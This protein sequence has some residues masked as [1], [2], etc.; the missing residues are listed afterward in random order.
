[1]VYDSDIREQD[2]T[3][4]DTATQ[5]SDIGGSTP[6]DFQVPGNCK[7]ITKISIGTAVDWTADTLLGFGSAVHLK[8]AGLGTAGNFA[9]PGPC[10][11]TG[12]AA[13]TSSGLNISPAQEYHTNIPVVAGGNIQAD[14]YMFGEDVGSVRVACELEYD[15]IPGRIVDMDY[16]ESD[17]TAANTE[18]QLTV[19][20]GATVND[21]KTSGRPIVEVHLN[22]GLKPVAGPLGSVVAYQL[23][24]AALVHAGNYMYVGHGYTVQDDPTISGAT[25]IQ[26][27]VRK[28]VSSIPLKGGNLLNCYAQML[29]DDVGT[30]FAV[31]GLGFG[32]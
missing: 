6:G 26:P 31:C 5:L 24:G 25:S 17:L 18:V 21:F 19:R 10:G 30:V 1:M 4:L 28:V 7:K 9:F 8:G 3:A 23:R 27:S 15:G 11:T 16:R 20:G 12:G 29:N 14:G 32:L 2:I 22:G 13:A